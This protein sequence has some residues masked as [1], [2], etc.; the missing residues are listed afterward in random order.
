MLQNHNPSL[1]KQ[2]VKVDFPTMRFMFANRLIGALAL[3]VLIMSA[4]GCG[5][6]PTL[7][8]TRAPAPSVTQQLVHTATASRIAS[9]PAPSIPPIP[10]V[11]QP[12]QTLFAT[13]VPPKNTATPRPT[14]TLQEVTQGW[15]NTR[16][17]DYAHLSRGMTCAT[18][19]GTNTP[20]TL[21]T[22]QTCI[23]CHPTAVP[24]VVV[25]RRD[26]TPHNAHIG[27]LN[28]FQCHHAHNPFELY[29]NRC[30]SSMQLTRFQ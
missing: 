3:M 16:Y 30:H 25:S 26:S 2:F 24:T 4:S 6:P 5:T 27:S 11:A 17:L 18:C 29:C 12:T 20:T 21:T 15:A 19:H 8:P 10:T 22:M 13:S 14:K 28:C 23:D 9:P 7:V 1:P